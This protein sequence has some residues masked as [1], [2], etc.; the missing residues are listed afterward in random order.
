M[1]EKNKGKDLKELRDLLKEVKLD[2]FE[3]NFL[4]RKQNNEWQDYLSERNIMNFSDLEDIIDEDLKQNGLN[5]RY[6]YL[7]P[8]IVVNSDLLQDQFVNINDRLDGI[9]KVKANNV[10]YNFV[11]ECLE[12]DIERT[13]ILQVLQNKKAKQKAAELTR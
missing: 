13:D 8:E 9:N 1:K 2:F 5:T 11:D 10:F 12:S 4:S 7:L 6:K 3:M